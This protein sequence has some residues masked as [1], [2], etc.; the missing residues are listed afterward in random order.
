[1]GNAFVM[2]KEFNSTKTTGNLDESLSRVSCARFTK[3]R[4]PFARRLPTGRLAPRI[5]FSTGK[6][7][8]PSRFVR[9]SK[10]FASA[11]DACRVSSRRK[12]H[13][14]PDG[15]LSYG[16]TH[17]MDESAVSCFCD[18]N[19]TTFILSRPWT[20]VGLSPPLAE[21]MRTARQM[22]VN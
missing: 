20:G 10:E 17:A 6:D 11:E 7:L 18:C 9:S 19:K 3:S 8:L 1:M 13:V 4:T 22:E 16:I 12:E 21:P 2:R 15:P 14:C 5:C